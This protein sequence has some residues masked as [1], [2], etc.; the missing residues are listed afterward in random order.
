[1]RS[2]AFD[3]ETVPDTDLGAELLGMEGI[4]DEDVAKAMRFHRMQET[5][6][7]DFLPLY[8]HRVVA[9]SVAM[10][11][12]S[13]FKVW[14]LGEE[15][16]DEKELIERFYE[17][18][19]RF[20]PVLVS[21]N[22]SGFDLPVLHYRALKHKVQAAQYWDMGQE[23][24]DFKWNNYISRFHWRHID[25]MDVLAGF[26]GR[27][28][29]GLDAIATMLG[30]PGKMGMA[31]DKVW[32]CFRE[33]DIRRIR[34]Y[35]ETDVLNTHLVYTRFQF[36]RGIYDQADLDREY[37][38]IRETLQDSGE[39]HLQDFLAAWDAAS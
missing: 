8:Q 11:D 15:D 12:A 14:S 26:Q 34:D 1:M 6:G 18:I 29:A 32:D 21:W 9:I 7:N 3:I 10:R 17:G 36:M 16:S 31:G 23:D 13:S 24:R 30:F 2:I 25:L 4:S 27:A 39:A 37:A 22:G 33:G 38:V 35:C 28:R 5:G 19:E 20:T